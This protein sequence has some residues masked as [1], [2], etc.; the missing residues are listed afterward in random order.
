VLKRLLTATALTALA[1]PAAAGAAQRFVTAA[2]TGSACTQPSPCSIEVGIN[3]ATGNDEVIAAP[4]TYT[5]STPLTS[6]A[7]DL[8]V[9]GTVGDPPLIKT[10]APTGFA[11]NGFSAKA[12]D[13]R[14]DHT[15]SDYGA[16]LFVTSATLQRIEVRSDAAYAACYVGP[17]VTFRDSTCVATGDSA[18]AVMDDFTGNSQVTYL[19]NDT[20]IAKGA[21]SIGLVAGAGQNATNVVSAENMIISGGLVDARARNSGTGSTTI[22]GIN[23]SNFDSSDTTGTNSFASVPGSARNQTEAPRFTGG[24][25]YTQAPNSPTVDAGIS[26]AFTGPFDVDGTIRPQGPAMD[27]G[28]DELVPDTTAPETTITKGPYQK[29]FSRKA[30]FRFTSNEPDSTF[31]CSLDAKKPESC[32]SPEKLKHVKPGKH[33]F[34]VVAVDPSDNA[35]PTAATYGWKVKRRR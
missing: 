30:K 16:Q 28:A 12:S 5:T 27:I 29:T 6:S 7:N 19:R 18:F 35:D 2:G 34:T 4:G 3:N 1:L 13:L 33:R 8:Y 14:I 17:A 24:G 10:S 21:N 32:R 31:R 26:D 23:H 22:L 11:I 15:G 9:H 25:S 20:A